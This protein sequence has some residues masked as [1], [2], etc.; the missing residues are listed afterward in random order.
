MRVSHG[1]GF[2]NRAWLRNRYVGGGVVRAPAEEV[3][4]VF[5]E[6]MQASHG[7]VSLIMLLT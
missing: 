4:A 7:P 1:P 2:P 3:V 5:W 6:T